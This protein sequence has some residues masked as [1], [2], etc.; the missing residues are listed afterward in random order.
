MAV[1]VGCSSMVVRPGVNMKL[2]PWVMDVQPRMEIRDMDVN[3]NPYM[4]MNP[5]MVASPLVT[6]THVWT[7]MQ[8]VHTDVVNSGKVEVV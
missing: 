4:Q 5:F 1:D 6:S 7:E 8:S 2:E 3:M